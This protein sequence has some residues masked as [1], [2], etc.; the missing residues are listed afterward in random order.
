MKRFSLFSRSTVVGLILFL[1]LCAYQAFAV[2]VSI[3]VKNSSS[4]AIQGAT[5]YYRTTGQT[6]WTQIGQTNSSGVITK[7]LSNGTYDFHAVYNHT[8]ITES[9]FAV[10]D[11]H[12][13]VNFQTI[14]TTVSIKNSDDNA[15]SGVPVYFKTGYSTCTSWTR[16]AY[17]NSNG[18]ASIETFPRIMDFHAVY[19]HTSITAEDVTVTTATDVD[20]QTVKTTVN[21]RNSSGSGISNIPV[22]FKTGYSTC[23]TWTRFAY[24]NSNGKASIET[25]PRTMDFHAV[26]NQTTI[27]ENALEVRSNTTINWQTVENKVT[28]L[29]NV[30]NDPVSGLPAYYRTGYLGNDSFT[31]FGTTNANGQASIET[32]E[33]YPINLHV[34]YGETTEG[35]GEE[36]LDNDANSPQNLTLYAYK[37]TVRVQDCNGNPQAGIEAYYRTNY[38]GHTSWN[39][40]GLTESNGEISRYL[41]RR[42]SGAEIHVRTLPD[43]MTKTV[44]IDLPESNQTVTINMTT[45][46]L[47]YGGTIKWTTPRGETKVFNS[48][49][50]MF[51]REYNIEYYNGSNL[52]YQ[53]PFTVDENT[54]EINQN[55][56]I[57]KVKNSQG[58]PVQNAKI[59]W[60][61]RWD[62]YTFAGSTNQNGLLITNNIPRNYAIRFRSD[63]NYSSQIK[64]SAPGF[65][66]FQTSKFIVHVQ[67]HDGTD[68]SGIPVWYNTQWEGYEKIGNSDENGKVSIELFPCSKKFKAERMGTQQTKSLAISNSGTSATVVLKT[69]LATAL[70]KDCLNSQPI[71]NVECSFNH[72]FEGFTTFGYTNAEGKISTELFPFTNRRFKARINYT[73]QIKYV[74]LAYNVDEDV[75]FNPVKVNI[76]YP[77]TVKW[78]HSFS[79]YTNLLPDY[80]MFPGTYKF[81]FGSL[82]QD[83]T[84]VSTCDDFT[85]PVTSGSLVFD[86]TG[87]IAFVK[88][89]NSNNQPIEG[90]A[91]SYRYGYESKVDMGNTNSS[92]ICVYIS[93]NTNSTVK[94]TLAYRGTSLEKSQNISSNP[95]VL[96][97]TRPVIATLSN[98]I[99]GTPT[100]PYSFKYRY[101]YEGYTTFTSG[102]EFLPVNMKVRC[103]YKGTSVEHNHSNGTV[104]EFTTRPVT[105]SLTATNSTD[106]TSSATFKYRYGYEGYTAFANNDEFLPVNMKVRC[107]YKGT[108]VEHNH[109]NGTVYEFTTRPVTFSLTASNNTDLTSSATFKYRYGYEGYTAFA[110]NDEFLP[111]NMK[112]RCYYKGTSVEHNHSNGTEY[113]FTTRPVTFSLTAS[114]GTTDLTDEA[115]FK[116]RYGYEGYTAFANNDEFLPVNMKVRCYYKGTS[117]EKNQSNGTEY[118]F[119]TGKV[120]CTLFDNS[121]NNLTDAATFKY[122]YGYETWSYLPSDME[123]LPVSTKFKCYY[124]GTS[125]EKSAT[126][127]AGSTITVPFTWDGSS[128]SKQTNYDIADGWDGISSESYPNPFDSEVNINYAISFES[129]V[130]IEIYD[131]KGQLVKTLL[132]ENQNEGDYSVVWDGNHSSGM[133]AESGVYIYVIQANDKRIENKISLVR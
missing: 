81:K 106:L 11:N 71:P 99:G 18:Q 89:V 63:Y 91:V 79:G 98:S 31:Q 119:Q 51:P 65:I 36:Y 105:F 83:I 74:N 67:K 103:Y 3:K 37:T 9:S 23:S 108:S 72:A 112:V 127:V 5:I 32:F 111:V 20:F 35:N 88:F 55:I 8:S 113:A 132:N 22:Y 26:Y 78:N 85:P 125:K 110:N 44:N 120:N 53:S 58:Q 102:D 92:G 122:R 61:H 49:M 43:Y 104:Y 97:T 10:S 126:V 27:S 64:T 15:I 75:E 84:I 1:T 96:F 46:T 62:G 109:S 45:V 82:I 80:Y 128:L 68:F 115:T 130:R 19:N 33:N 90:A 114:N 4:S 86:G 121:N 2:N 131:M 39:Y 60:N 24:T 25:F 40:I 6:S 17:T 69:A 48:P 41:F 56:H 29:K 50:L 12:K 16:F 94:F 47:N 59:Y 133:P 38:E 57:F 100:E 101:G 30:S 28:V 117:V 123:L 77:E 34:V 66:E 95:V 76:A 116:Y 54:C 7:N 93:D 52:L 42:G 87:R 118:A 70:V 13:D 21:I 73:N 107:Y 129:N 124:N 14:K